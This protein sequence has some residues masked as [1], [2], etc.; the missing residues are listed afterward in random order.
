MWGGPAPAPEENP[1]PQGGGCRLEVGPQP[2][3][4]LGINPFTTAKQAWV[5]GGRQEA[6]RAAPLQ[7]SLRR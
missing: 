5:Q 6:G 2:P 3:G 4:R 7:A 1:K